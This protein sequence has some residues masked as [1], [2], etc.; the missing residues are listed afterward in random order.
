MRTVDE[1][2]ARYGQDPDGVVAKVIAIEG[3]SD[4][5]CVIKV[6]VIGGGVTKTGQEIRVEEA[7]IL[8]AIYK[9]LFKSDVQLQNAIQEVDVYIRVKVKDLSPEWQATVE[10][11]AGGWYK[12]QGGEVS[13]DDMTRVIPE[14]VPIDPVQASQDDEVVEEA[15]EMMHEEEICTDEQ[16]DSE[17][18]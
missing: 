7:R 12:L 5:E 3:E 6:P 15:Y 4:D 16:E 11:S 2:R 10:N 1:Y 9:G 18:D 14:I 17:K 13:D 8:A